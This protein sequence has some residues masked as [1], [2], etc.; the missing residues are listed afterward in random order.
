M[1]TRG[2]RSSG[3][4]EQ[5]AAAAARTTTT[6]TRMSIPDHARAMA[7]SATMKAP[8]LCSLV[9]LLLLGVATVALAQ[10]DAGPTPAPVGR[11]V[12]S[13]TVAPVDTGIEDI[14][15][16]KPGE[17]CSPTTTKKI[18]MGLASVI[19]FLVLFFLMVRLMERV[20][21]KQ[22]KSPLMGRHLGI[23]LALFLGGGAVCGIFFAVTECW[24]PAYTYWAGFLGIVWFLHFLYTMVA[25]RK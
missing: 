17:C 18:I 4:G 13:D 24:H 21:I 9:V 6:A 20:F 1:A 14:D 7:R 22:E 12:V 5:A 8:T 25:I 11:I 16:C 23:S 3:G 10:A 2:G 19:S 15:D